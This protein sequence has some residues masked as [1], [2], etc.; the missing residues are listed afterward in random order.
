VLQIVE[1][2]DRCGKRSVDGLGLAEPYG[3]GRRDDKSCYDEN[4]GDDEKSSNVKNSL[5]V[6]RFHIEIQGPGFRYT[7]SLQN[8][9][10][11]SHVIESFSCSWKTLNNMEDIFTLYKRR[12]MSKRKSLVDAGKVA[13]GQAW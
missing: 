11:R 9:S 7:K 5:H 4:N 10:D 1:C 6:K 3:R 2:H 12:H 8:S 13:P